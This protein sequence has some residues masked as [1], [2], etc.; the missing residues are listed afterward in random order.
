[1]RSELLAAIDGLSD[2]QL[3]EKSLDGW[4]VKDHLAHIALWDE[5]R[6]AEVRR[7]S[8][9]WA[10]AWQM[11][12]DDNVFS[13]LGYALREA[14]SSAQVL[15]ELADTHQQLLAAIRQGTDRTLVPE[16]YGEAAMPSTHEAE[17]AGWIRR[18]RTDR[19]Y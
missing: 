15:W 9:G 19:G 8:A 10:S 16:N 5:L 17:H 14:L 2:A 7:V 4:S 18:W 6:T 11:H 13:E 1:M 3:S 12:G